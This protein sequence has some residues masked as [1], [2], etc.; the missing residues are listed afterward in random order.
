MVGWFGGHDIYK[1][2]SDMRFKPHDLSC[3]VTRGLNVTQ[4]NYISLY[5]LEYQNSVF[6]E[7]MFE[8]VLFDK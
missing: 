6:I 5:P 2:N 8:K 1:G 4:L 3:E 7:E